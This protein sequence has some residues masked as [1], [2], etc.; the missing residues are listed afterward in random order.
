[1]ANPMTFWIGIFAV[2][3]YNGFYT[4]LKRKT[5]FAVIPGAMM[6]GVAPLIGWVSGGGHLLDQKILAV[7]FFFF[8]WQI[9]H[10]WLLLLNYGKEYERAGFPSLT[11]RFSPVQ[12]RRMTFLWVFATAVACMIIPLFGIVKSAAING[13][14]LAGGLL[15]AGIW[16]VW[17]ASRILNIKGQG[18]G[19]LFPFHITFRA[20]NVY[21]LWVIFLFVL[22]H[23]L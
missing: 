22:D 11:R 19:Q 6:G 20:I 9:P 7:F 4:P 23:F 3:W 8:I 10:F 13:G 1:M 18:Q 5:A 14:L 17:K 2:L 16:L 21:V 15:A 12:F